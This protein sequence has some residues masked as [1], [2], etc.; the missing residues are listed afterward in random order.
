M[1]VGLREVSGRNKKSQMR[2][3]LDRFADGARGRRRFRDIGLIDGEVFLGGL[4]Q[5]GRLDCG[6]HIRVKSRCSMD[7]VCLTNNPT[8]KMIDSGDSDVGRERWCICGEKDSMKREERVEV[9]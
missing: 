7:H 6:W 5:E 1:L 4:I 2:T 3:I 8:N 9:V